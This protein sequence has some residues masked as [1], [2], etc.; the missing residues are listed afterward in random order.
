MDLEKRSRRQSRRVILS[1]VLMTITVI[2][3]VAILA[4]LVS[5][6]WVNSDLT[7]ERQGMLQ[8]SSLPTGASV[9]VDGESSW[10]QR[11]NTSKVV[12]SGEHTVV[13]TKEGY[14]S[15]SKTVNVSEGLLYRLH[16]PRLFLL[17]R[18]KETVYDAT[19]YTFASVSPNRNLVLLTN[20][21]TDW[22]LL[23]LDADTITEKKVDVAKVFSAVSLAEGATSGLFTGTIKSINWAKDSEHILFE[24]SSETGREWV[25]LN[26]K[27]PAE[28][29]NLTREFSSDFSEVKILNDSA[30][31]LLAV[32][33][34][35][36]HRIDVSNRQ[37]SAVIVEKIYS[38]DHLDSEIVFSAEKTKKETEA[39]DS[40]HIGSLKLGENKITTL[41]STASP[42]KPV[43]SKFYDEEYITVLSGNLATLY[44]KQDFAE[45]FS[46]ELSFSPEKLKVGHDG[47]FITFYS[48]GMIATL[49]MESTSI[50]EWNVP[51]E[52]FGWVDNDMIYGISDGELRV[53]DFD[54]FN[55]R[56][57]ASNASS[58]F[59]AAI[60]SDKWLYYFSDDS[61]VR[62]VIRD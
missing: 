49:D 19:K 57:L 25:V 17:N 16:Y 23:N 47:E 11:T 4:L 43:I 31:S 41:G 10:L 6:Y 60:V 8:I 5:G 42:V 1:E 51:A 9:E 30:S 38:F 26:V 44:E 24:I 20:D 46:K 50:R 35:N 61:L 54:G 45:V 13:L 34:G 29:V 3:T 22:A 15:W 18:T 2:A 39:E 40:Y 58:H 21:T 27:N 37:L 62:E 14:D 55:E 36:L 33:N 12:T 32:R 28:K 7:L 56:A 52:G 59:P 48:G 53:Y